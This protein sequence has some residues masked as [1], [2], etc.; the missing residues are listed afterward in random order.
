VAA[1]AEPPPDPPKSPPKPNAEELRKRFPFESLAD[2]LDYEPAAAEALAKSGGTT[3][4][5]ETKGRLAAYEKGLEFQKKWTPRAESLRLLHSDKVQEFISR[6]GFGVSRMLGAQPSPQ[7]LEL[8]AATTLYPAAAVDSAAPGDKV[9]PPKA[10]RLTGLHEQSR[11]FF[12]SPASFG[13]VK[14]RE[15]VAGFHSHAFRSP[16]ETPPDRRGTADKEKW[17]VVR[18]ELVSLLKHD[19]PAVYVSEH[20]PR[21]DELKGAPTRPLTPFE[22]KALK[23][24]REG[25]DLVTEASGDRV[26]M[27][28][29]LRAVSQ[30]LDCHGVKRG[31]LLGAFSYELQRQPAEAEK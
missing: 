27:A 17:A 11:I 2:R 21:M 16:P 15:H 6:D 9:T 1:F 10:E 29:S 26:R 5:D 20:L 13:Y 28:G 22:E 4:T 12:L 23:A 19:E 30:C 3:L 25:D 14:D 8:P 31:D 7:F 24:M 18:L